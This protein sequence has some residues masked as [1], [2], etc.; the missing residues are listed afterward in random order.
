MSI[1]SLLYRLICPMSCP[2]IFFLNVC[3]FSFSLN[4][5]Q[6]YVKFKSILLSIPNK[7][8][9]NCYL[10]QNLVITSICW[11]LKV[12]ALVFITSICWLFKVYAL[13]ITSICWL[14]KVYALVFITSKCWLSSQVNIFWYITSRRNHNDL[15]SG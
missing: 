3:N 12:Y 5:I 15:T 2:N 4:Y 7:I 6:V 1:F 14:L 13:V 11:L 8:S 10:C 9:R